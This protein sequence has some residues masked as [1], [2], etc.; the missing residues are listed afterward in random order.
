MCECINLLD[1]TILCLQTL[2]ESTK[3]RVDSIPIGG[4]QRCRLVRL[5]EDWLAE[6]LLRS[7]WFGK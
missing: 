7:D 4:R 5:A 2:T 6:I 1:V 3:C